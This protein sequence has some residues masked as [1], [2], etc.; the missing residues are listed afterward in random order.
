MHV[1]VPTAPHTYS[2]LDLR[3]DRIQRSRRGVRRV[4]RRIGARRTDR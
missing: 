3:A 2:A 4:L 1:T